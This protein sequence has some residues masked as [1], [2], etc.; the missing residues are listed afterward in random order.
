MAKTKHILYMGH[1]Q[2][3]SNSSFIR[4]VS[5]FKI[6][7]VHF[8]ASIYTVHFKSEETKEETLF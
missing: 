6:D 3:Q 7:K 4:A 2:F 8:I 1:K 5:D